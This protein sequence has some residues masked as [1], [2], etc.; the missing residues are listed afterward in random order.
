MAISIVERLTLYADQTGLVASLRAQ[1][2]TAAGVATGALITTGFVALG[3]ADYRFAGNVPDDTECVRYDLSSD[4]G[5]AVAVGER[6]ANLL[7]PEVTTA[8]QAKTTNLPAAPAA[9]GSAMTLA[10]N[11]V[12]AASLA[13][14]AVAEIAAGISTAS[15]TRI[16]AMPLRSGR[17]EAVRYTRGAEGPDLLDHIEDGTGSRIDITGYTITATMIRMGTE[18]AVFTSVA[19][20]LGNAPEEGQVI[21][22]WPADSLDTPG[23]YRLIWTATKSGSDTLTWQT[24]VV[25]E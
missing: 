21:L 6:V 13:S 5:V 23:Q 19:A 11:A 14:D 16:L 17:T 3:G 25:V 20:A 24:L 4:A 1:P 2:L 7:L 10:N 8:I 18:V 12:T 15:S 9:V 22:D